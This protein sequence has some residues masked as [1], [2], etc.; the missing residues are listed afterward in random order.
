V[1]LRRVVDGVNTMPVLGL[2]MDIVLGVLVQGITMVV[3][4]H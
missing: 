1:Q 2:S 4:V 3:D